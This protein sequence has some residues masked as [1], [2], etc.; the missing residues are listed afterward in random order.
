MLRGR[1]VKRP[2][3][4]FSQLRMRR[5]L[6]GFQVRRARAVGD[7]SP[8]GGGRVRCGFAG[9]WQSDWVRAAR[10]VEDASPYDGGRVRCGFAR[11]A[12]YGFGVCCAGAS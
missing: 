11:G 5:A 8:Y 12:A 9:E 7:A 10:A 6:S 2:Y 3:I 1:F 4:R